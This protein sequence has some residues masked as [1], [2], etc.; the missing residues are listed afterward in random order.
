MVMPANGDKVNGSVTAAFKISE[1]FG[2]VKA[3]YKAED[4][5]SA[6]KEFPYASLSN[7]VIGTAS[8]P[9]SK[10]MKF[11]FTDAA[12]NAKLIDTYDFDI[13][14]A[15]DAPIVEIHLPFENQIIVEDFEISGI[16]YDD[17]APAKIH[18]KIDNA[19]YTTLDVTHTF[20]IPVALSSLTDNEHTISIYGEDIYGVKSAPVERK[21]RV[22]LEKPVAHMISPDINET[23]KGLITIGGTA[24][25][26][27]GIGEV[28]ISV[29]N[30]N[31]FLRTEGA[32]K[33]SYS[34]NTQVIGDGTHVVLIKTI[35]KYGLESVSSTL[36]NTDNT[37]P[38]LEIEYPLAGSTLG[39]Y[40]A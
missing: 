9:I 16:V 28:Y 1:K 19:P 35:D 22:S 3:E 15:A 26:G 2:G 31:S 36:I 5:N 4:K 10:N 37:P 38:S 25:D 33:W 27:N 6:W 24:S 8:E 30:G 23:V 29:N 21:I 34:L 32:E 13:D 7:V 11:R 20:S 17:D 40:F 39:Q 18:Y 14:T 12:G